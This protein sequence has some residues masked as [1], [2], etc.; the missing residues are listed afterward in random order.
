MHILDRP[1]IRGLTD[2]ATSFHEIMNSFGIR[3]TIGNLPP[4]VLGFTYISKKNNYHLVLNG[5]VNYK[6]QCRTFVHELKHIV[7]DMPKVS[8]F[9]GLDMQKCEFE[10]EADMIV[11]HKAS[12]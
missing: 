12:K 4:T 3:V 2:E 8:Y 6:T 1:L 7:A 5:N 9:V 10:I 11:G